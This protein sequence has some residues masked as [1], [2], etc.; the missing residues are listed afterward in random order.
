MLLWGSC[1]LS[2]SY[3][4]GL[5]DPPTGSCRSTSCSS[6]VRRGGQCRLS[7]PCTLPYLTCTCFTSAMAEC[8]AALPTG[9]GGYS[10]DE[11]L[12]IHPSLW[13]PYLQ[14]NIVSAT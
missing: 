11:I 5:V 9:G 6:V 13:H 12:R 3:V 7:S 14:S 4:L 10:L 8:P 1:A 2:F